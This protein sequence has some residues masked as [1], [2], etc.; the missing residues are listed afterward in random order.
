MRILI[1]SYCVFHLLGCVAGVRRALPSVP[2]WLP[3]ETHVDLRGKFTLSP[4]GELSLEL[5]QPCTLERLEVHG[6]NGVASQDAVRCDPAHLSAI[7][8][9]ATTPWHSHLPGAWTDAGHLAFRV[10]WRDSDL[11]QLDDLAAQLAQP[12][13]ISESVWTPNPIETQQLRQLAEGVIAGKLASSLEITGFEI[14]DGTL[15][16]GGESTLIVK[17][18]NRGP[19]PAYGVHAM[20]SSGIE[21]LH[22]QRMA[23]GTIQPGNSKQGELRL[24]VPS[25][26]TA[27][28]TILILELSEAKGDSA[29]V[30]RRRIPIAAPT[31]APALG[32]SCAIPGR[33][34]SQPE[35]DAG[36]KVALRCRV[37]NAG[38][39]AASVE[40]EV[41]IAGDHAMQSR[42]EN[43]APHGTAQFEML[44]TIPAELGFDAEVEIAISARDQRLAHWA[45]TRMAGVIRKS[46]PCVAGQLTRPQ[47]SAKHMWLRGELESGHLTPEQYDRDDAALVACLPPGPTAATSR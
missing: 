33:S 41:S 7:H 27:P 4:D 9:V 28:D 2:P 32:V 12:W 40:L 25:W 6:V 36:E 11:D 38:T 5:A 17:I 35:L 8:V 39:E 26:E 23:F 10:T 24:I 16:A 14:S 44:L 18:K 31:T 30:A 45:R 19:G 20:T 1:A 42:A 46:K 22:G 21:S 3:F 47:Y 43:V 29:P 15:R 34:A 37:H 13:P